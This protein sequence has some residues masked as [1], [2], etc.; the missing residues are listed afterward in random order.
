MKSSVIKVIRAFGGVA[1]IRKVNSILRSLI[2][3]THRLQ[4]ILE[5]SVS[6]IPDWFDHR[7]DQFFLWHKTRN[8][9]SWERGIFNLLVMKPGCKV[10]ELCCGDGFNTQHFYS[11]RAG[12]ITSLDIDGD[13]ILFAKKNSNAENVKFIQADIR[14]GIPDEKYDNVIWDASLEYF[15]EEEISQLMI[16]IK[17]KLV[18]GGVLSGFSIVQDT[19]KDYHKHVFRSS[20]DLLN[21]LRPYYR[22]VKLIETKY[23]TRHNLYFFASDAEIPEMMK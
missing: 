3:F 18:P 5:W 22:Y 10:L 12:S 15:T 6:P 7:L 4:F 16:N 9:G 2:A 20:D 14:S 8:P 19:L 23:P 13:A 11:V 17:A 1:F 21:F